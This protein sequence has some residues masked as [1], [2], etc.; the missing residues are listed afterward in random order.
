ML[1]IRSADNKDRWIVLL[2]LKNARITEL[3][4]EHDEA[5]IGGPGISSWNM[6][7]GYFSWWEEG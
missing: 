3:V 7:P 1:D 2:N 5:W 4:H 6:A